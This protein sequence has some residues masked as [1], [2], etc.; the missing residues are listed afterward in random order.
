MFKRKLSSIR[1]Y[2]IEFEDERTGL[3]YLCAS[4]AK[5]VIYWWEKRFKIRFIIVIHSDV[6]DKK[7][8]MCKGKK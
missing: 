1:A 5:E 3:R 6:Y 2:L 4:C 8:H 7:C